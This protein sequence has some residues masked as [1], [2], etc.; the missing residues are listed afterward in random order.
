MVVSAVVITRTYR[1]TRTI[2]TITVKGYAEK[3]IVSDLVTWQA[4]V[5]VTGYTLEESVKNLKQK[6][7]T[8]E[9]FIKDNGLTADEIELSPINTYYLYQTNDRGYNTNI[10]TGVNASQ[11]ISVTSKNVEKVKD[12]AVDIT[13]LKTQGIDINSYSPQY[14][15]TGLNAMKMDLLGEA[16]KNAYERATVIAENGDSDVGTLKYASQGVFQITSQGSN[17]V[18][19]YGIIDQSSIKKLAKAVVTAEFAID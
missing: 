18:S 16:T 17:E 7:E 2:N 1:D 5:S 4:N 11:T 15:F 14:D 9:K 6:M 13:D 10:V 12:I 8:V 3:E 19:D